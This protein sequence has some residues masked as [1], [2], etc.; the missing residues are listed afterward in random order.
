METDWIMLRSIDTEQGQDIYLKLRRSVLFLSWM[1]K[2]KGKESRK[3]PIIFFLLKCA[4]Q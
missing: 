4:R 2:R 1:D 3:K